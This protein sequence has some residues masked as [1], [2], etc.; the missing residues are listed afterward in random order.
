MTACD[1]KQPVPFHIPTDENEHKLEIRVDS[2]RV[3]RLLTLAANIGVIVGIVFLVLEMRQTSAIATAQVRLE[4]S[5]GWRSVDGS[6]QDE[7]FSEVI[8]K[9]IENPE[10]LSLSEVIRLDA[11]YSG[12]LDQMLSA[13]T[14]RVAG[15]VDGPFSEVANTVGVMYFSDEF[16]RTWWK[17]VRSDW[18]Y[19]PGN[20]FQETMDEAIITGELGRARKIYEGIQNELS[21]HPKN[22]SN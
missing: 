9:S 3:T 18:S 5:A 16:A 19:R 14:A 13:H 2:D 8:T 22:S 20:E 1:P 15:L 7:S 17:Q 21:Q 10:E 11:Y 6:R 4:Y 12:I